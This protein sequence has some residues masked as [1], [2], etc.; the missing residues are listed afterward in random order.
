VRVVLDY[1]P[2]LRQR[3]GVGE[4]AHHIAAALAGRIRA[5]DRLT[6]FSSSWKDRLG[7]SVVPGADV[8]DARVPVRVL[9]YAWHRLG[10]P[11]VERILRLTG[12]TAAVDVAHSLHPLLIPASRAAQVVTIHDLHFLDRP[13][14]TSREVRRD[15]PLLASRHAQRADAVVVVSD[16]TAGQVQSRLGVARE[17]IAI[18]PPGAPPWA[19]RTPPPPGGP[20]LFIGTLEPRKN[21]AALLRAYSRLAERSARVPPLLLVGRVTPESASIMAQLQQPPLSGRARHI[22]YVSDERREQLYR[23]ASVLVMPSLNEGFGLPALEA[24]T[25]GL[26]VVASNRGNLPALVG[27]AGLLVEPGDEAAIGDAIERLIDDRGFA[28]QCAAR[29]VERAAA[30]TWDASARIQLDVYRAAIERRKASR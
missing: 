14:D 28:E 23:E 24:M 18:V 30:F 11:P 20:V 29:G 9:N 7:P 5:P 26:P 12:D 10:W 3:T 27:D 17:R 13:Q 6:L 2:A 4:Y 16:Y 15:Y 25:V 19:P 1:R 22:G 8:V 21:V